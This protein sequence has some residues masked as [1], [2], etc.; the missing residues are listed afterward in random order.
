MQFSLVLSL[1]IAVSAVTASGR[2]TETCTD[3]FLRGTTL[4]ASC[5]FAGQ[6]RRN[7][8]CKRDADG[9]LDARCGGRDPNHTSIDLGRCLGNAGGLIQCSPTHPNMNGCNCGL[10]TDGSVQLY[11]ECSSSTGEKLPGWVDLDT[12]IGN[13]DGTLVC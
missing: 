11:C 13:N 8:A 9:K 1:G 4:S 2:F 6:R 7:L 3:I 12:C 10:G 5:N